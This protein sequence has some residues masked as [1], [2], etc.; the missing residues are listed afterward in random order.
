MK[1]EESR[2]RPEGKVWGEVA[3]R[4]AQ[5]RA[6]MERGGEVLRMTCY[7]VGNVYGV[8]GKRADRVVA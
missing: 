5:T 1:A 3:L 7:E 4:A 8:D 2:G 6:R